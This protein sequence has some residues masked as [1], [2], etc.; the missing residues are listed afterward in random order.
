MIEIRWWAFVYLLCMAPLG[1]WTLGRMLAALI[2]WL[3]DR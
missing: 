2:G 3:L 1:G